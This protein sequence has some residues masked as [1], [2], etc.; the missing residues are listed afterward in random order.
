MK[1]LDPIKDEIL[2]KIINVGLTSEKFFANLIISVA[3]IMLGV[4]LGKLVKFILRKT[5]EKMKIDKII[6]QSFINLFLVVVKWSIYILFIDISLVQLNL[7]ILTIWLTTILGVIPSLTGA[8]IIISVG[9]TIATYLKK[10]IFESKIEGGSILSQMFF[11][12]VNYIFMVFAFKTALISLQDKF[13]VNMLLIV[14]TVFGGASILIYYFKS[15][16]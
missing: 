9:F 11:Y 8:L 6:K 4:F 5:L 14:F 2:K 7:P 3:L 15:R 12:F 16:H 10:I 13:I 1:L